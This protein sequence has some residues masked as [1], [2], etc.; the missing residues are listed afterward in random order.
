[1]LVGFSVKDY[2]EYDI[3][4]SFDIDYFVCDVDS[5]VI[6]FFWSAMDNVIFIFL[7]IYGIWGIR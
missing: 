2:I 4:E 1:M 5:V 3:L 6:G 7:L